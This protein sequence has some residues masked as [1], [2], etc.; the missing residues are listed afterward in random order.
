MAH[1][2]QPCVHHETNAGHRKRGFGDVGGDHHPPSPRR[3]EDSLLVL[4]RKASK[5]RDQFNA[6]GAALL[7]RVTGLDDVAF[8]RHE[9]Q[10]IPIL[11]LL[12]DAA[13][14]FDGRID[15]RNL[16]PL[17]ALRIKRGIDN[18][19]REHASGHFDDRRVAEM[20]RE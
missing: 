6:S 15:I 18:L 7:Q 16:A 3:R 1:P 10:Q 13:H 11:R 20:L 9:D 2:R 8:T 4:R 5:E 12:Q 17:L 14:R 19:H